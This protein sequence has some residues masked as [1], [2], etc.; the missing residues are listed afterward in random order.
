MPL[1]HHAR[2]QQTQSAALCSLAVGLS[3]VAL[4]LYAYFQ[5]NAL[6]MLAS[7]LESVGDAIAAATVF[8]ALRIAHRAPDK[9][10][11]WGHGK[12]EPLV[13]LGQAT[14]IAGSGIY[15]L[16][17]S[18][19]RLL[20]PQSVEATGIGITVMVIS[21]ILILALLIYQHRIVDKTHSMSI[22][23]DFLHYMND[24]LVNIV[25][26]I[27]LLVAGMGMDWF[28]GA[29]SMLISFYILYSAWKLARGAAQQLMDLEMKDEDRH[30]ISEII[31]AHHGVS[32][33]HD[34]RT[35]QSG[36]DIF[37][38]AHVEMSGDLSLYDAH[39]IT[40][41]LEAALRRRYANAQIIL[42]QEPAGIEDEKLD[43]TIEA[44]N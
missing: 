10:H 29:A 33:M 16:I 11:R 35:R 6:V 34:L 26:I 12:A 18:F 44:K 40:E 14:F 31:L 13:T 15:F 2:G 22:K 38:D 8:W 4:Q 28:D 25:V 24:M 9:N 5:T 1:S 41:L 43:E 17:Q 27:A 32:G 42:H 39:H 7:M 36:P 30:L 3:I 21:S 23:A 37:I 20:E 19:F